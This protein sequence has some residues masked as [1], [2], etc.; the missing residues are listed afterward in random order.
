MSC[1]VPHLVAAINLAACAGAVDVMFG[2]TDV[3]PRR[4]RDDRGIAMKIS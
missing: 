3:G 1:C 4:P 2:T